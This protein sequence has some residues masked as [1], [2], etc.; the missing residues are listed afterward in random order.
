MLRVR[1]DG[2]KLLMSDLGS[3]FVLRRLV[4]GD[5]AFSALYYLAGRAPRPGHF[6]A[7]PV[8]TPA[9]PSHGS[10][11]RLRLGAGLRRGPPTAGSG[12]AAHVTSRG[13]F[14]AG[15]FR[16]S[17]IFKLAT[18]AAVTAQCDSSRSCPP[19]CMSGPKGPGRRLANKKISGKRPLII[20]DPS[21]PLILNYFK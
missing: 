6:S 10:S 12:Q 13:Y 5:T 7:P 11:R 18:R 14:I 8:T 9:S 20:P 16:D 3:C 17:K 4:W 2:L 1:P 21:G 19:E 15:T